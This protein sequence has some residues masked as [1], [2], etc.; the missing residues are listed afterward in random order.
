MISN[1]KKVIKRIFL[2]EKL[3][4]PLTPADEHLQIFENY[5]GGTRLRLRSVRRPSTGERRRYLEQRERIGSG[6]W[7]VSALQLDESEY[8]VFRPFRGREIRK[9]RYVY[10]PEDV[11]YE[12][13]AFLG[14]L[15]GLNTAAVEFAG[16][17]DFRNFTEPEFSLIELTDN[18]FFEGG[19]LVDRNFEDV[20]EEYG[21]AKGKG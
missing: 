2:I 13:D 1:A 18:E 17:D 12:I 6:V 10:Q 14:D 20:R 11:S 3:P 4:D 8:S 5:I 7:S 21:K 19:N 9:N 15:W 16:I